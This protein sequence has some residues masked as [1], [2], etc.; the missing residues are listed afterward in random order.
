MSILQELYDS[1]INFE[2]RCFWDAGFQVRLGDETNGFVY[3]SERD[4][5]AL[6]LR[7]AVDVLRDRAVACY[8]ESQFARERDV[9]KKQ[10]YLG[11]N[12]H[13]FMVRV[14]ES[15][16]AGLKKLAERENTSL[17]Y[18]VNIAVQ[19]TID[20]VQQ[21]TDRNNPHPSMQKKEG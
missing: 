12:Y 4:S 11:K 16:Y 15:F 6:T 10:A 21:A 13:S 19:Q 1:E 9:A 20:A 3:E 17:N 5:L 2:I 18:L 14:P 8:P 7:E